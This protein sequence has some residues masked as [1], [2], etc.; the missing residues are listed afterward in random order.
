MHLKN[1][2]PATKK[3]FKVWFKNGYSFG[4]ILGTFYPKSTPKCI[5]NVPIFCKGIWPETSILVP[6]LT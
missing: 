4:Y 6:T 3:N 5:R 2:P 1:Y